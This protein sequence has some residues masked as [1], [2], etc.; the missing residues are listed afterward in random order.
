[1]SQFLPSRSTEITFDVHREDIRILSHM[2]DTESKKGNLRYRRMKIDRAK[3][4]GSFQILLLN[5][6]RRLVP[7]SSVSIRSIML[8]SSFDVSCRICFTDDIVPPSVR[9]NTYW[10]D[11]SL[12]QSH[13]EAKMLI[14]K[15]IDSCLEV[16][17]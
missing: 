4:L 5:L 1:M 16:V 11:K 14:V 8:S 10:S 12:V 2:S 17:P 6:M 15:Y 13:R 7:G 9:T 3:F